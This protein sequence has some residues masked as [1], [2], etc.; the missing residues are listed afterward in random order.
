MKK[1][2]CLVL[3]M[4]LC[5]GSVT[6]A[7]AASSKTTSDM[8]GTEE[9][10]TSTGSSA[11][12]D[13]VVEPIADTAGTKEQQA[14]C[15]QMVEEIAAA[16]SVAEFF[17]DLQDDAGASLDLAEILGTDKPV[18]NEVVP[19]VVKN[20]TAGSG[21]MKAS[22]TFA[23]PYQKDEP[24]VVVVRVVDPKTGKVTQIALKGNGNGVNGGIDVVFPPE[25]LE[26]IQNGTATMAVVSK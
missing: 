3:A 8:T 14:Q 17:G 23:T 25:V 6:L 1:L 7:M 18:V 4:L 10:K 5:V 20:Y 15:E 26:A 21:S 11:P 22:F 2:I 12:K 9:V 24:V 19:L 16:G 13:L